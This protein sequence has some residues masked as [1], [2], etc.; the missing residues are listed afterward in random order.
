MGLRRE[1]LAVVGFL[2]VG[3]VG[4]TPLRPYR[5]NVLWENR[6]GVQL[7]D[8]RISYGDFTTTF[9]GHLWVTEPIA[10]TVQ[11]E[12]MTPDGK[13]HERRVPIS[14]DIRRNIRLADLMFFIEPD[15]SVSVHLRSQ[16]QRKAEA[17][18]L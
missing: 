7:R 10:D 13:R 2:T 14:D 1:L 15:L 3:A 8:V 5:Y 17:G 4:C 12:F 6:S 16:E 11:V 18:T 9:G